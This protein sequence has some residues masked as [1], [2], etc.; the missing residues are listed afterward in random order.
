M[1]RRFFGFI[2]Q[3]CQLKNVRKILEFFMEKEEG[4][5][6]EKKEGMGNERRKQ[7]RRNKSIE[8]EIRGKIA[9]K[10]LLPIREG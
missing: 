4:V 7:R 2:N 1:N 8:M 5:V 3:E 6:E 10:P 9:K